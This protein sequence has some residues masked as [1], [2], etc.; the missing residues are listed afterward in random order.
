MAEVCRWL[1]SAVALAEFARGASALTGDESA[2]GGRL[3]EA[4]SVRDVGQ[5]VVGGGEDPLCL[6]DY[7][8]VYQV[9]GRVSG[10]RLAHESECSDGTAQECGV[11]RGS[12]GSGEVEFELID[13]TAVQVGVIVGAIGPIGVIGAVDAVDAQ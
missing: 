5:R 11:V 1:G 13:E 2:E 3:T 10:C 8:G 4:E 7:P 6:Q 9:F 12:A